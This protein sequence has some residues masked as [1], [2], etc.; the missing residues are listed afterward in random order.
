MAIKFQLKNRNP[1]R[2][3]GISSQASTREVAAR[4]KQLE[5]QGY[6]D[7]ANRLRHILLDTEERYLHA[8]IQN[9][10]G[11]HSLAECTPFEREDAVHRSWWAKILGS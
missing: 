7:E 8:C 6:I 5:A 9:G 3:L 2:L 11:L 10:L 1:Y 4:L